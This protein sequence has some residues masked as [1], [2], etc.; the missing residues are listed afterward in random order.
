MLL[1][2][3][4]K[5]LKSRADWFIALDQAFQETL[6]LLNQ[7]PDPYLESVLAQLDAMKRWTADG[8]EP[9]EQERKSMTIGMIMTREFD[10]PSTDQLYFYKE[11]VMEVWSYF[12]DW[13]DD[14]YF[15]T[16]DED[17]LM[18]YEEEP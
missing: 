4:Y 13:F 18:D 1:I 12:D 15:S 5:F 10:S 7:G 2:D 11:K 17:D 3:Q 6:D 14:A 16:V 9:T 8:R